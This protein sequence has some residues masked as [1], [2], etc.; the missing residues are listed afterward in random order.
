MNLI[1]NCVVSFSMLSSIFVPLESSMDEKRIQEKALQQTDFIE[2]RRFLEGLVDEMNAQYN[3]HLTL[4]DA[5]LLV[6]N[7]IERLD[8]PVV[9]RQELLAIAD[10]FISNAVSVPLEKAHALKHKFYWPWEWNFF[11]LNKNHHEKSHHKPSFKISQTEFVLPDKLAAGFVCAFSG[12]LL[13]IVPGGQG[14]G[15]TLIGTGLALAIDG[16]ANGERPYYS[17]SN[18]NPRI[19]RKNENCSDD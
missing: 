2:G 6:K 5:S 15:L 3:L 18:M 8:I 11:G 9:M 4:A 12:A 1:H 7:N 17:E 10:L 13:C 19:G 14:M 16:M